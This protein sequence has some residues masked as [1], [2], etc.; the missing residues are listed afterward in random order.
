MRSLRKIPSCFSCSLTSARLQNNGLK[1]A[2]LNLSQISERDGGSD[3]GRWYYSI[4]YRLLR[5]LRLKVDLQTW[6]Q[7]N[8]ILSN[9]QRLVEFFADVILQN[10]QEKIVIFVDDIQDLADQTAWELWAD[11]RAGT[12]SYE[13]SRR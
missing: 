11:A 2:V 6:W 7:D 4:A 10:V 3:P 9:R 5:Q 8:S 13:M 1:V 12:E